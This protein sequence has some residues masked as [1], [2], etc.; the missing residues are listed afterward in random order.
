[1]RGLFGDTWLL[2]ARKPSDVLTERVRRARIRLIGPEDL[3]HLREIVHAWLA[4]DR[5]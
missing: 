4:G 1:V 5:H 3:A 2:S